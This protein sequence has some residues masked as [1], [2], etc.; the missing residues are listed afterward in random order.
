MFYTFVIDLGYVESS[1][2]AKLTF[3]HDEGFE[4]V[5]DGMNSI[6]SVL[7]GI[8]KAEHPAKKLD[9]CCVK[10]QKSNANFCPKC[11]TSLLAVEDSEDEYYYRCAELIDNMLGMT[12]DSAS[13]QNIWDAFEEA[14][15][16]LT[17]DD[18][19]KQDLSR[20]FVQHVYAWMEEP[21][22][23]LEWFVGDKSFINRE[24]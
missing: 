9:A 15:W 20:V 14:G 10:A 5:L 11:G 18:P 2:L 4:T 7:V 6:R 12:I 22:H 23:F 19:G 17:A 3:S 8:A 24:M 13:D 16:N 1:R 21:D